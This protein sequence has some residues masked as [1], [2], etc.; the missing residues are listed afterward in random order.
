[1]KEARKRIDNKEKINNRDEKENEKDDD[2]DDENDEDDDDEIRSFC[3]RK[4]EERPSARRGLNRGPRRGGVLGAAEGAAE[5][6]AL[7]LKVPSIGL[8]AGVEAAAPESDIVHGGGAAENK[9]DADDCASARLVEYMA[10]I[11]LECSVEGNGG[12]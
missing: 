11:G 1:M 8:K 7:R 12:L 4:R 10:G 3:L 5:G 2:D 6:A 9:E